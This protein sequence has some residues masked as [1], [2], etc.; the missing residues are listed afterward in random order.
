MMKLRKPIL[1]AL[2]LSGLVVLAW[3][4]ISTEQSPATSETS[5]HPVQAVKQSPETVASR[6]AAASGA[7]P[8]PN[9][10]P[11]P[12]GDGSETRQVTERQ[13]VQLARQLSAISE[14]YATEVQYPSYSKPITSQHVSYLEPNRFTVVEIPVL[15]GSSTAALSLPKYRFFAPEGVTLSLQSDL[16][17]NAIRY[18]FYDVNNSQRFLVKHTDQKSL[19]VPGNAR[20]PQEIRV[21][22]TVDFDQ[23]TDVL[24]ADFQYQVPVA[25]VLSAEAPVAQGAD[26]LIPLNLDVSEVGIYRIRANLYREDGQVIAALSQ[27]SRLGEGRQSLTLKAHQSVLGGTDGRYLL[28]NWVVERMSGMPGE[29]ASFGI[30]QQPVMALAPFDASGLRREA[31]TPSPQEQQRLHFLRQAG[32]SE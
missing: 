19:L 13:P 21:K 30:S 5:V 1:G 6:A 3:G 24:T 26:M 8:I 32:V 28:K 9:T 29:K 10:T 14:V 16:A 20:W 7:D 18:E 23:G 11:Q 27:K 2:G 17:V 4:L 31:Y 12:S 22:A 15:G 25:V